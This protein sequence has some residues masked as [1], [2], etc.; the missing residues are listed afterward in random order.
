MYLPGERE[1]DRGG[2]KRGFMKGATARRVMERS[3]YVMVIERKEIRGDDPI[4]HFLPTEEAG[5]QQGEQVQK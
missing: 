4:E 2:N 5:N 1:G 3:R